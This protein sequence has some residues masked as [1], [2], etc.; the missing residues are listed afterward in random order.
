MKALFWILLIC[1]AGLAFY[2]FADAKMREVE[3]ARAEERTLAAETP[4]T[5]EPLGQSGL[6]GQAGLEGR[7]GSRGALSLPVAPAPFERTGEARQPVRMVVSD[8]LH[9]GRRHKGV[10]FVSGGKSVL[11]SG[12]DPA[13]DVNRRIGFGRI[14]VYSGVEHLATLFLQKG[15][16]LDL[17]EGA[18]PEIDE[19]HG[20]AT[21]RMAWHDKGGKDHVC[22]YTLGGDDEGRIF[23]DYDFGVTEAEARALGSVPFMSSVHLPDNRCHDRAY[24]V[25]TTPHAAQDPAMLAAKEPPHHQNAV[26]VEEASDTFFYE[27][28]DEARHFTITLPEGLGR[29][30]KWYEGLGASAGTQDERQRLDLRYFAFGDFRQAGSPVRTKGRFVIDLCKSSAPLHTGEPA[31]NGVD[32]WAGDARHV[33]IP[34]TR[35]L[36]RNGSFEQN[37]KDWRWSYGGGWT[38]R[39]A[40]GEERF[41]VLEGGMGGGRALRIRPTQNG[42]LP[43][44][45]TSVPT[46]TGRKYT[47]SWYARSDNPNGSVSVMQ[48]SAGRDGT[49]RGHYSH[50]RKEAPVKAGPE[51]ERHSTTFEGTAAGVFVQVNGYDTWVDRIML[52]EGGAMT[53][54]VEDPVLAR[55]VTSNP[56][57]DLRPDIPIDAR[58]ELRGMK[59]VSG[60]LRVSVKNFYWEEVFAETFDFAL[61]SEP[62]NLSTFQPA[63]G[64]AEASA[65]LPLRLDA[66]RLGTG[67]FVARMDFDAAGKRWTDYC[68][69]CIADPL[70]NKHP[71]ATF[72]CGGWGPWFGRIDRCVDVARKSREWGFGSLTCQSLRNELYA[73]NEGTASLCRENNLRLILHPV[74]YEL[75]QQELEKWMKLEAKDITDDLLQRLED[76]AYKSAKE[77]AP[78]DT[79]WTFY[80]EEE[81]MARRVGFE[82]HFKLV[83]A[84]WRGC[85]RAFDE[86][87]LKLRFAPTHGVSHYFRGRNYDAIDGYLETAANH[88]FRY[89]AVTIHSYQNI[90]GSI[91]GPKDA[92]AETQHLID[93]MKHYGYPDDTPILLS[94][95][96]NI[97]P[98]RVPEWGADGWADGCWCGAPSEDFSLRE[99]VHAGAMARLYLLALKFYPKVSCVNTWMGYNCA[100]IDHD[101]QP[102]AWMKMVNTLGHLFPDPRY[103]GGARPYPDVR[104][105]VFLQD[106]KAILAVWTSNNDVER[107][108]RK[109]PVLTMKLPA[110]ATFIDLMGNERAAKASPSGETE[111]PLTPAPLFI[112]SAKENAAALVAAVKTAATDD[113]SQ[114]IE[115]EIRPMPDGAVE[116]ELANATSVPQTANLGGGKAL[117]LEAGGRRTERL[118]PPEPP[119]PMEMRSFT[120]NYPFLPQPWRMSYFYIPKCGAKPDWSKVPSLPIANE[121]RRS[122]SKPVTMKASFQAA[123]NEQRLFLRVEVKDDVPLRREAFGKVERDQL[124]KIDECLEVYFDAFA[125][126]RKATIDGF[127]END[128]RYDFAAGSVWRLLAVNWQL[129]QGT[130]S[131]TDEEVAE[132][133]EQRWR[134]TEKGCIYEIAFAPR[135]LAP[136]ELKPGTRAS[137]GL[138]IHDRDTPADKGENG[139]SNATERGKVCNK[140][141]RLWPEFILV[142]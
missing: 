79:L 18:E 120:A 140:L 45:S 132:K 85:S 36:L 4:P 61:G 17:D 115:A 123:W 64:A 15:Y 3:Q 94:E 26:P 82:N 48:C 96:F 1:G 29:T 141:P 136:I 101:L 46:V 43:L 124:Y 40:P 11:A 14:V 44:V 95:C 116:M 33:P 137:L 37:G 24:G 74:L 135:Y 57:S 72:F 89:D 134:P 84:A 100:F 47:L 119:R 50:I 19:T 142:P 21:W 2:K 31:Y 108:T 109:G 97:L 77:C 130:T 125:D 133:L 54:Y 105:H 80:N 10:R 60:T 131:A 35:N 106:D 104:G 83:M 121:V 76:L 92:E 122:P 81:S 28:D 88:G 55:L 78:D 127:D 41:A 30:A 128:S 110:D 87:G 7:K 113:P 27:P 34:P 86:R 16:G 65:T 42:V 62:F 20:T 112:V 98:W 59:P 22:S 25:G 71:T 12:V 138:Y 6:E 58:L 126:G 38:D 53:D 51:W 111:V 117:S 63:S 102:F 73:K 69:F 52:E 103:Y 129:A 13:V 93:R 99:F 5:D 67:V 9:K 8:F 56:D 75:P 70:D 68:R 114:A 32:F 39:V 66:K 23:V 91:L 90:D 118:A 139:L 49:G 107:G